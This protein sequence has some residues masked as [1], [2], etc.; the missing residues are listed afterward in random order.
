MACAC[1]KANG[2]PNPSAVTA[3]GLCGPTICPSFPG[4]W[5]RASSIAGPGACACGWEKLRR[6]WTARLGA[7]LTIRFLLDTP[8]RPR[9][10]LPAEQEAQRF[11]GVSLL[12]G[13]CQPESAVFRI[14]AD[15]VLP[16]AL[17]GDRGPGLPGGRLATG[18]VGGQ[19]HCIW[20]PTPCPS[21]EPRA[22][23]S[24]RAY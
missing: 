11:R 8:A 15:A 12:R 23:R 2:V 1:G 19:G 7:T 18:T 22:A 10:G 14:Q 17:R 5:A 13:V 24:A 21:T 4:C 9:R 20:T 6:H 3:R 16:L